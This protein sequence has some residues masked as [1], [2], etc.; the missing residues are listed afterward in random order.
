MKVLK[1]FFVICFCFLICTTDIVCGKILFGDEK[2]SLKH[3]ESISKATC[4]TAGIRCGVSDFAIHGGGRV[5]SH[6]TTRLKGD[7]GKRY[8]SVAKKISNG[9]NKNIRRGCVKGDGGCNDVSDL[10]NN[11]YH[12]YCTGICNIF[13]SSNNTDSNNGSGNIIGKGNGTTNRSISGTNNGNIIS[14]GNSNHNS[15]RSGENTYGQ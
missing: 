10:N 15:S 14:V 13:I 1:S 5:E 3:G 11:G 6:L 4:S 9:S 7:V 2:T 12:I 8:S